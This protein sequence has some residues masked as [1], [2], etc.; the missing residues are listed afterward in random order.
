MFQDGNQKKPTKPKKKKTP[1][2][3]E[4]VVNENPCFICAKVGDVGACNNKICTKYYHLECV[5]L[6]SWPEGKGETSRSV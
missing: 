3:P 1:P 6:T 5:G 4:V 2:L